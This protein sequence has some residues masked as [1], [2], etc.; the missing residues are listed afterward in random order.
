MDITTDRIEQISRSGGQPLYI[1]VTDV[2]RE[3]LI[4]GVWKTGDILPPMDKIANSLKVARV[5]VREAIKVLCDE[6]LLNSERGRGTI[7]T[8]RARGQRPLKLEITLS[9][10]TKSLKKDRPNLTNLAEEIKAPPSA[11]SKGILAPSYNYIKRVHLRDGL[12]YCVINLYLPTEIYELAPTRFQT[13]LALPVLIDL[14][15]NKIAR[16]TQKV[17]FG[18][19][20][21]EISKQLKYPIGDPVAYITREILDAEGKQIYFAN[22]TYRADILEIDMELG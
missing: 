14:V 12:K 3:Q 5:T 4:R 8:K 19:C 21:E 15:A 18:K 13:Q 17:R 9:A 11:E 10:L 6:G 2:L 1:Q 7:V 22:V 20:N 16:V